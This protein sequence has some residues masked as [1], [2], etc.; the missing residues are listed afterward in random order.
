MLFKVLLVSFLF[1]FS[2]A[3]SWYDNF[4][5]EA[6]AGII[7][8]EIDGDIANPDSTLDFAEDIAYSDTYSSF[9][10]LKI[11]NNYEYIPNI[12]INVIDMKEDQDSVLSSKK[13]IAEYWDYNGSITSQ[14]RYSVANIMLHNTYKLKGSMQKFL[15]WNY[16]SG[17]VVFNLG[18]NVKYIDYSYRMK[19]NDTLIPEPYAFVNVNTFVAQPYIKMTYYWYNFALYASGSA[20]SVSDTKARNY[21]FGIEYRLYKDLFLSAGYLYEDLQATEKSDRVDFK[22]YGNKFTF[23]YIF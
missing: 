3:D 12:S 19:N 23:K 18:I 16:Y 20:L 6:E 21:Q 17:D 1:V 10:G 14:M 13:V 9:F 8:N 4:L 11:E 15:R 22:T 2:S 7:M 5:V